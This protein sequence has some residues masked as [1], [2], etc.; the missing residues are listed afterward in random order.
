MGKA[1]NIPKDDQE[2]MKELFKINQ[3]NLMAS[4]MIALNR[5]LPDVRLDGCVRLGVFQMRAVTRNTD[6]LTPTHT[7]VR[8]P[9]DQ[10][11]TQSSPCYLAAC[12]L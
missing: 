5:S 12:K 2:K 6:P 10:H 7:Y 3:F 9:T 4:D 8:S 1:V 11:N